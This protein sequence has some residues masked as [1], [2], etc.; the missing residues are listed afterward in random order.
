MLL[1]FFQDWSRLQ[2]SE[3]LLL[4]LAGVIFAAALL[5]TSQAYRIAVVSTV[6]PFEYLYI[7]W[8]S[9]IG[10]LMFSDVPS[11]RILAGSVIVVACGCFIIYRERYRRGRA[12]C[13][14][15]RIG[16]IELKYAVAPRLPADNM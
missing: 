3:W 15:F 7:L 13:G 14:R 6:A 2:T 11:A 5:S 16:W 12:C 1:G 10:Y 8:A 9:V 4:L